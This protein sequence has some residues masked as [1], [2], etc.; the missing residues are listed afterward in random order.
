MSTRTG[1]LCLIG[2]LALSLGACA[3]V[4]DGN[5]DN[6]DLEFRSDDGGGADGGITS[7][8]GRESEAREEE[9]DDDPYTSIIVDNGLAN[10]V[11][12]GVDPA[13]GLSGQGLSESGTV[14]SD[15]DALKTAEYIVE[16]AL[17]AGTSVIKTLNGVVHL[18]EGE[19]GLAPQWQHD[20]CDDDCQQWVS[21]CLLARANRTGENVEIRMQADHTEIGIGSTAGL[22]HEASFYGNVFI[23]EAY[24]C[25]GTSEANVAAKREGRTCTSGSS[26]GFTIYSSCDQSNRCT[27][28]GPDGDVPRDCKMGHS[29]LSESYHTIS[30]FMLAN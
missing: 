28:D 22:L 19:L 29:T 7:N 8:D 20:S 5:D 10:S 18:F 13:Y 21:A 2:S 23:G 30:T 6:F 16:C 27:M 24:Y 12:T 4:D 9:E 25:K 26:C 3:S 15:P 11:V 14:L 1:A 17:P